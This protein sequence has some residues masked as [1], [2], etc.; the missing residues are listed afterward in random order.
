MVLKVLSTTVIG[1]LSTAVAAQQL[2][3]LPIPFSLPPKLADPYAPAST[4]SLHTLRRGVPPVGG[5]ED[6]LACTSLDG[7]SNCLYKDMVA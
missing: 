4:S 3:L 1:V 6:G 7:L 2:N 5:T